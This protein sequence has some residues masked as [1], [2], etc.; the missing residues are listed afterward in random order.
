MK[1]QRK[2]CLNY[3]EK[4]PKRIEPD[5]KGQSIVSD[6]NPMKESLRETIFASISFV[7]VL[8][9]I[10]AGAIILQ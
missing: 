7:F 2:D 8:A 6:S 1:R 10:F 9:V 5:I 3:T 4:I